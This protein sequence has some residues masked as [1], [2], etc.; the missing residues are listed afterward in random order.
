MNGP[1]L[2]SILARLLQIALF[3]LL[4]LS[5]VIGLSWA[6]LT[7]SPNTNSLFGIGL[8]FLC[9]TPLAYGLFLT[10]SIL[11]ALKPYQ[12]FVLPVLIFPLVVAALLGWNL[13]QQRP[14]NMFRIFVADPIPHAVSNIQ[15]RDVS[16]GFDTEILLAFNAT[17]EAIDQIMKEKG[18]VLVDESAMVNEPNHQEFSNIHWDNTWTTYEKSLSQDKVEIITIWVNPEK[19]IVLFRYING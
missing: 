10:T 6:V 1:K 4:F 15:A 14:D 19:N 8:S 3:S 9:S 17:P 5:I 2:K 13:F 18:L 12:R 7:I 11:P 16:G